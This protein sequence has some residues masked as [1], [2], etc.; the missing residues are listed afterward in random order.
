MA[1][2]HA[3]RDRYRLPKIVRHSEIDRTEIAASLQK[4]CSCWLIMWSKWRRKYTG[5]ACFTRQP[6]IVDE[7]KIDR[8][9]ARLKEVEQGHRAELVGRG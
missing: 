2:R 9:L 4:T 5:F 8:F 6:V 3:T 7:E 1:G